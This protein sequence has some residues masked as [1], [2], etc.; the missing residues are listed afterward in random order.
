MAT[1]WTRRRR[2][3]YVASY[4]LPP[5]LGQ[6][7]LRN[8]SV[9]EGVGPASRGL[10]QWLR[11]QIAATETLAMPSRAVDL[12]W[13]E[14]ILNTAAYEQFCDRAYGRKL[15]HLP[16]SAMPSTAA[17]YLNGPA[18]A[19]TFAMACLDEVI[20]PN[21]PPKL[22]TLFAVDSDLNFDDGLRWDNDCRT[23]ECR[24]PAGSRCVWHELVPLLPEK[25]PEMWRLDSSGQHVALRSSAAS[26]FG[27]GAWGVGDGTGGGSYGGGGHG[28]GH[29]CGGGHG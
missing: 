15:H 27:V 18:M 19:R 21:L 11:I 4:V 7:F 5:G 26:G 8:H 1:R 16:E 28:G 29:G 23:T 17:A 9:A 12:L 2:Q 20:R 13:H 25:L 14:F 6:E 10:R 24:A 22:P 3:R